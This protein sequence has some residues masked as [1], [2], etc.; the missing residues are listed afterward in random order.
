M[1]GERGSDSLCKGGSSRPL[2]AEH[3]NK[4]KEEMFGPCRPV[5]T[6]VAVWPLLTVGGG[7]GRGRG[8]VQL[9][10]ATKSRHSKPLD[11]FD[12][13]AALQWDRAVR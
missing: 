1:E 13:L 10:L 11:L 4:E 5:F 12:L 3:P 2:A 6:T 8:D 7:Q 9:F